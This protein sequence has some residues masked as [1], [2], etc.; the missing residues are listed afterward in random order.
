MNV[1]PNTADLNGKS[2]TV[3]EKAV[4]QGA[5]DL[6]AAGFRVFPCGENKRPA[7]EGGFYAATVNPDIIRRWAAEGR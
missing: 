6:A 3:L 2:R 1:Q 7:C 4:L 5:L